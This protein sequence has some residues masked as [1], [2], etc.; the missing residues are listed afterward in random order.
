[1]AANRT[2]QF[3]GIGYGNSNVSITASVNSTQLY[4]GPIP[5]LDLP[6][7]PSPTPPASEQDV[8]F[9]IPDN[10]LLNTNFSGSLPMTV[11]V[12]GGSGVVLGQIYSNYYVGNVQTDP[13]AG[14]AN[15]YSWCYWG[16]PPNSE[17][18]EDPRSSVYIDGVQQVPPLPKSLGCWNWFLNT[19]DTLTYNWN[20]GIGQV[21]N[22]QG[23]VSGYTGPFT[24]TP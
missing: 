16:T 2:F 23:N 20:I 11:T 8:L 1:M 15:N 12:T 9:E 18:T 3:Y 7:S 14:T 6:V 10:A 4:S 13:N 19:G 24:T 17:G 21:G 22:I 5:T